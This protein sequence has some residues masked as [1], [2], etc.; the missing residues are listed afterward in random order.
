MA[1]WSSSRRAV[2]ALGVVTGALV[3]VG[4]AAV[5]LVVVV[6]PSR[7]VAGADVVVGSD[8]SGVMVVDGAGVVSVVVGS[9]GS[10]A[11]IAAGAAIVKATITSAPASTRPRAPTPDDLTLLLQLASAARANPVQQSAADTLPATIVDDAMDVV[12]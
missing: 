6:V 7:V 12:N 2:V 9:S 5:V 1:R 3:S 11:A 4:I 10:G 8:R